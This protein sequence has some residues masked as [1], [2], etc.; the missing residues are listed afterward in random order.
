MELYKHQQA[1]LDKNPHKALLAWETGVGKTIAAV[2]WL[3]SR[4]GNAVVVCPKRILEKWK[5][6][7]GDVR[8]TVVTKEQFKKMD[9]TNPTAFVFDEAH[10]ASAPLFTKA[11]SQIATKVYNLIKANPQMPVLLLTATPISSTPANLHT[12]LCYTGNFIPWATWREEFYNLERKPFLPRPAYM[13][14]VDWR[15][16]IRPY[17][18]KYAHIALMSECVEYLPPVTEDTVKV[19]FKPFLRNPEWEPMAAFVAEHRNEQELKADV[20]REMGAGYRKVVVVAHFRDQIDELAKSLSKDR[21]TYV[22]H[23]GIKDQEAVIREAQEDDECYLICQASIGSGFDLDTFSVMVFAS[24]NYSYVSLKQ[25]KG[26]IQRIHALKP[27]KYVYLVAGRC[28][29]AVLKRLQL[30]EDFDPKYFYEKE[31]NLS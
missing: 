28:D 8:A 13:P 19:K 22:L 4:Q 24:L 6:E 29:K 31:E 21:K 11:R 12:L 2:E 27:V 18:L 15:K 23:G 1:F 30:G 26:R 7:L 14:K 9:F 20:I 25:M 3:R 10:H 16:R 17:L 5:K